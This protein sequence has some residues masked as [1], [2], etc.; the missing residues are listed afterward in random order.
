[1]DLSDAILGVSEIRI[2]SVFH[3]Q[4][5]S[6]SSILKFVKNNYYDRYYAILHP[7]T[8]IIWHCLF[9]KLFFTVFGVFTVGF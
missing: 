3:K 6:F 2:S 7:V 4:K 9:E 1:M 5:S 8:R